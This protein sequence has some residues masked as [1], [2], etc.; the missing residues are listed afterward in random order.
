MEEAFRRMVFNVM[1]RNCD[2]HTKNFS[3]RL[4]RSSPWE[5]APAYDVAFAH[6]PKGEWTNQ[7]LMSVNGK[8]RHISVDDF[9]TEAA[10]FGIGSAA[11]VIREVA[12]AVA[13]W[14][15]FAAKAGVPG[16]EVQ[17][18]QSNHVLAAAGR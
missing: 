18:I 16:A 11:R 8:F 12:E 10:R 5:L 15:E 4:M 14:P 2:D 1:A 3:F 7:H 13:A 17:H 9:H 6:N